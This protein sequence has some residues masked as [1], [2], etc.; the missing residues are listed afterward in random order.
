CC[1]CVRI[2]ILLSDAL[3]AGTRAVQVIQLNLAGRYDEQR[4]GCARVGRCGADYCLKPGNGTLE[5]FDSVKGAAAIET[6]FMNES[7]LR[8]GLNKLGE[9]LS[10]FLVLPGAEA[11]HGLVVGRLFSRVSHLDGGF[12]GGS[13]GPLVT[14]G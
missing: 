3:K 6:R 8:I 11:L 10:S 9:R 4:V 1:R 2:G 12:T 5:V 7:A 14:L 13:V